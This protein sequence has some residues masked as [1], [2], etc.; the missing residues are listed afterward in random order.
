MNDSPSEGG[1]DDV[2]AHATEIK[3]EM[4]PETGMCSDYYNEISSVG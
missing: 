2:L 3:R 1:D 4:V